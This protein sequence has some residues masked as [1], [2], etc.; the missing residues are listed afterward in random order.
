MKYKVII[1]DFDGTIVESVG[2]K[3]EAFKTLFT[4][5]PD[6]LDEITN[7]HLS[8]N[9]TIRFE[10][11]RHIT[12]HILNQEYTEE[13]ERTLS[14]KFSDLVFQKIIECPYVHGAKDFL[15]CFWGRVPLYLA[16]TSPADE[17]DRILTARDI[18]K[19]FKN[20]YA[21]PWVKTDV[22]KDILNCEHIYPDEAV[23]VGDAF[24]DY[25]AAR[26]TGVHFIGRD[27]GK[28]IEKAAISIYP[29][30]KDILKYLIDE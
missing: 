9:A 28:F 4:K 25:R 23:F 14:R 11:F 30:M 2:I 10:K 19:Y 27:S 8:H 13:L 29:G 5:Y 15:N 22:I 18:K 1:L 7:Y 20:V 21:I 26:E 12:K 24:E 16:S 17:L 6:K 3:D